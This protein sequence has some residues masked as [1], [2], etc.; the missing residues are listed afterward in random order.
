M[1]SAL[2]LI[3]FH[4]SKNDDQF[5]QNHFMELIAWYDHIANWGGQAM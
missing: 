4:Y 1:S 2:F 3:C 5:N